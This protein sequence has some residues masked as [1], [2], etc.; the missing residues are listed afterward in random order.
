MSAHHNS[1]A[2][3]FRVAGWRDEMMIPLQ[4][5]LMERIKLKILREQI[6]SLTKTKRCVA[7][8]Y[9]P[10]VLAGGLSAV[11]DAPRESPDHFAAD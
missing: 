8:S 9:T 1:A 2:G 10:F 6:F 11:A 4:Q 5:I 7:K 3:G